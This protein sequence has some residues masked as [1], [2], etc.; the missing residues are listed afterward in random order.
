MLGHAKLKGSYLG[1]PSSESNMCMSLLDG[2]SIQKQFFTAQNRSFLIRPDSRRIQG[3]LPAA[4]PEM[5]SGRILVIQFIRTS[6]TGAQTE[7]HC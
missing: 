1:Q 2:A 7:Q 5:L 3:L 6:P 4:L